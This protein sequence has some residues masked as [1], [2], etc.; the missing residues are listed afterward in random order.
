MVDEQDYQEEAL[1]FSRPQHLSGCPY[2]A[3]TLSKEELES[4]FIAES[5]TF[6]CPNCRKKLNIHELGG[7]M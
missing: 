1:D 6:V 7:G 2:C 3:E 4:S 5:N